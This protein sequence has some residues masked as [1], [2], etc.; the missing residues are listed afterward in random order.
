MPDVTINITRKGATP[1]QKSVGATDLVL[2]AL[3]KGCQRPVDAYSTG[4]RAQG[5]S[6]G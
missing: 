4:R 3:H 5:Q 2:R 1:A 6:H